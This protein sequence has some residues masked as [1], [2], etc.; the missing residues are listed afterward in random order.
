MDIQ[1]F[2]A[3]ADDQEP[4][5]AGGLSGRAPDEA[6]AP[7]SGPREAHDYA[8]LSVEPDALPEQRWGVIAPRGA[9]GDRLLGLIERLTAQRERDQEGEPAR[10]YRVDPGMDPEQAIRWIQEEYRDEVRRREEERPRYLLVLG[11]PELVSWDLQQALAGDAFVGRIAFADDRGYEAYAD[12]VLRWE[13][14][15]VSAKEA[16]ALFYTVRDGTPATSEGYR[17]LMRQSVEIARERR[18]RGRFPAEDIAEIGGGE[19]ALTGSEIE[20][21]AEEMLRWAQG[22]QGGVLFSMSHGVGVPRTRAWRS[23]DEQ[24]ATQGAMSFG[25]ARAPLTA[26]DLAGRPFLPGGVWLYFACFGAGT[27]AQSGYHHWLERLHAMGRF[28]P[29][30][31]VLATLPREGEAPFM[32]ALPEA[33]LA[34]K[35]GPLGVIGHVDLAWTWSFLEPD[36]SGRRAPPRSRPER[37]QGVLRSLVDGHRLG[38]AHHELASFSTAISAEL[39]TMYDGSARRGLAADSAARR[40]RRADLWMQ[41]QDLGAHVLLGDPAARLPVARRR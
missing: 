17:H 31:A 34:A 36:A 8:N 15:E 29:A 14:E 41:R 10:V 13:Q 33:A 28:G 39:A 3:H 9:A 18:A 1:L 4:V 38:V 12:K 5:L 27:P 35:D 7:E 40:G 19:G 30:D 20:R 16:R 25:R 37:F 26:A 21:H 32:A 22:A 11:G 6:P 24:R 23:P 2:L